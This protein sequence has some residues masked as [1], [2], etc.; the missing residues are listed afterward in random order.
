MLGRP[1]NQRLK[2]FTSLWLTKH[3]HPIDYYSQQLTKASLWWVKQELGI[4][5]G[6]HRRPAPLFGCSRH[7][8]PFPSYS[9]NVI[10]ETGGIRTLKAFIHAVCIIPLSSPESHSVRDVRKCGGNYEWEKVPTDFSLHM[11]TTFP[12]EKKDRIRCFNQV[13]QLSSDQWSCHWKRD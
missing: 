1:L 9:E 10:P 11:L 13:V 7:S 5:P 8:L 4:N 3:L 2:L 6:I 12:L